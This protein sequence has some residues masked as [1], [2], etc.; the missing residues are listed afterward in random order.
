[1]IYTYSAYYLS[2]GTLAP[3][4]GSSQP[5]SVNVAGHFVQ[6]GGSSTADYLDVLGTYEWTAGSLQVNRRFSVSGQFLFPSEPVSLRVDG[7]VDFSAPTLNV[8][9]AANVSMSMSETSLFLCSSSF[10]PATAFG[11][12]DNPGI[13]HVIGTPLTV[14]PGR[15]LH[16]EGGFGDP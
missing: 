8:T 9:R 7:I 13:T 10:D 1:N 5:L 11:N 6:T 4:Q 12:F 16:L 15:T 2:G 14:L 3:R